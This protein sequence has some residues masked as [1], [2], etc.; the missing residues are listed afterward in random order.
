M[1]AQL[2]PT[3]VFKA[4]G[5]DGEPLA[6]G[7]LY[8]Y[9]AGTTTPQVSYQDSIGTPNTNPIVLNARG[10][11][12]L[13]LDPTLIYKLQLTDSLGNQ[14]PG[15]PVDNIQVI[16]AT[17]QAQFNAL[18]ATATFTQANYNALQAFAPEPPVQYFYKAATTSRASN[19][20]L[21]NDPDLITGTLQPGVYRITLVVK[22]T[23]N[24]TG[25]SQGI[26]YLLNYTGTVVASDPNEIF[27]YIIENGTFTSNF[28][29]TFTSGVNGSATSYT[30]VGANDGLYSVNVCQMTSAGILSFQWAQK[31]TSTNP[32]TIGAGSTMVVEKIG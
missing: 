31:T 22:F 3:P 28:S 32:L 4:F 25:G 12:A 18:L 16:G 2:T 27:G 10:E 29:Q 30:T 21:T 5:N 26:Q 1:T 6:G 11:C 8:T 19:T 14:I 17:T 15:W 24:P 9:A 13:W 20:V 7:F 23:T